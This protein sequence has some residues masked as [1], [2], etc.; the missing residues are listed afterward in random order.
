MSSQK[1]VIL[2]RDPGPPDEPDAFAA[3]LLQRGLAARCVS[4]LDTHL[5][6]ASVATALLSPDLSIDALVVTS[7]RACEALSEALCSLPPAATGR[8]MV[9]TFVV[10]QRT[11]TAVRAAL[12]ALRSEQIFG[13]DAGSAEKL[14]P[15]ILLE[16]PR[17]VVG[18][19]GVKRPLNVLFLCGDRRL[20]TLPVQLRAGGVDV[21]EVVAYTTAPMAP[22]R[23]ALATDLSNTAA[24]VFFSPSGCQAVLASA[25]LAAALATSVPAMAGGG[26]SATGTTEL[27]PS[28]PRAGTCPPE[29][30][31]IA[32]GPTTA[33]ALARLGVPVA[34]VSASPSPT[35][36]ADAVVSALQEKRPQAQTRA[37]VSGSIGDAGFSGSGSGPPQPVTATGGV[38]YARAAA[39]TGVPV[40]L[41]PPII[42]SVSASGA[43]PA[44]PGGT[45]PLEAAAR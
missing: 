27:L 10:G 40:S 45:M 9:P 19:P 5:E 39:G 29:V 28:G 14:V 16:L 44:G 34:R 24:C 20:D 8:V 41:P 18:A 37:I 2:F 33:Q 43:D 38:G 13:A 32:L 42:D 26:S 22:D 3:A 30:P 12:P 31:C 35:A 23:I 36:L 15:I 7:H 17:L 21:L 11:A 25:A 1:Q 4:V 6:A